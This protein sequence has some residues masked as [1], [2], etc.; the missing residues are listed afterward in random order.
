MTTYLWEP[1]QV[2]LG[3]EDIE[4]EPLGTKEKF[5][6]YNPTDRHP[7]LFKFARTVGGHTRGEDWA[8]WVV[9]SLALEMGIPT[10]EVRA[11][12]FEGRRGIVSKS[13]IELAT[14]QRLVHGNS[15]LVES[16]DRYDPRQQREN[17]GYTVAAVHE[18]LLGVSAPFA[19]PELASLSGFDV[20][21]GYLV[22]DALVGGR[23]RHHE[24]WA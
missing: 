16:S 15:L 7:W 3:G 13:V 14:N 19:T 21:A 2:T 18:A 4:D 1:V 9:H 22:L 11:A 5:W 12:T 24:N 17:P 10:A 20:W 23:D 8:E 6:V